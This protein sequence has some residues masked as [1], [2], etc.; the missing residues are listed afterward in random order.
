V[1]F[2]VDECCNIELVRYL[3][4]GGHDVLYIGQY[5]PGTLDNEILFKAFNEKRIL[6]TEDKD[7]GELVY[8]LKKPAY[9]IVFLRFEVHERHLKWPRLNQ[10]IDRYEGRLKG[11]FVV[12]DNEKFRF[13]PLKAY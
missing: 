10:L 3:R 1:K 13:R 7:F 4:L 6:I 8:R 12:V 5:K 2:C 9:G 11:H